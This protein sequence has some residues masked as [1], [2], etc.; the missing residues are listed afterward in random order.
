MKNKAVTPVIFS[1]VVL[2]LCALAV[3]ACD[4]SGG[5]T[6]GGDIPGINANAVIRV[7]RD[8]LSFALGMEIDDAD[9]IV[10]CGL[11]LVDDEGGE[12]EIEKQHLTSGSVKYERFDLSAKG[13]NKQI[14]ITYKK[15]ESYIFYDVIDYVVEF[16]ADAEH[17]RLYKKDS[18]KAQFTDS[19]DLS[20]YADISSY[21]YSTDESAKKSDPVGTAR[22]NGWY[23]ESGNPVTGLHLF[24]PPAEG[25][26]CGLKLHAKYLT[27]EQFSNL[28]LSYSGNERVFS[29]YNGSERSQRV[30]VPEGVTYI[31][32]GA[33]FYATPTV[34][35]IMFESLHIPST[36]HLDLP[37]RSFVNT[38]GLKEIT[39]DGGS[40]EYSGY[41]GA[42][43]NKDGTKLYLMPASLTRV[44]FAP[45]LTTFESLSCAY[46]QVKKVALPESVTA[47]G[48][49]CFAY[50]DVEEVEGLEKVHNRGTGIFLGTPVNA[51]YDG[52]TALYTELADGE[53]TLSM[54]LDKSITSY[55]VIDGTIGVDGGA[56]A[57]C[58]SLVSVD[59]SGVRGIG[60]SAFSECTSLQKVTFSD[61]LKY[62]GSAVFYNCSSLAV[63]DGFDVGDITFTSDTGTY[64][65]TLSDRLF[66]G[67]EKLVSVKIPE[68]VKRIGSE[69][70]YGCLSLAEVIMPDGVEIIDSKAFYGCGFKSISLPKSLVS[71]GFGV[72]ADS[73]LESVDLETCPNLT[74]L[75][76]NCFDGTKLKTVTLP[77]RVSEIPDRCFY[78]IETLT[79][80]DLNNVKSVGER[81]FSYCINLSEIDFGGGLTYIGYRAFGNCGALTEVVL[82]D[83]VTVVDSYAFA[84]CAALRKITLG[85]N[86]EVFGYYPVLEDGVTFGSVTPV[87]WQCDSL[88]EIAVKDGNA[89]FTAVDGVLYGSE[90]NGENLGVGSVLYTIP[91]SYPNASLTLPDTVKIV[92]PYSLQ[93][94]IKDTETAVIS[95]ITLNEGIVNI[96]KAAF[97]NSKNLKGLKIPSTVTNLGASILLECS[98]IERFEIA[99]ENKV[100]FSDGDLIYKGNVLIACMRLGDSVNIREGTEAIESA[101][102]MG[103]TRITDVEIPSGVKTIGYQAFRGCSNLVSLKLGADVESIDSYAFAELTSLRTVEIAADNKHFKVVN[104][105]LYS[106]DGTRL[107]LAPALNAMTSLEIEDTVTEIGDWAFAYNKTLKSVKI[108]S[109]VKTIG[110]YAFYECRAV[111][112]LF[113]GSSL[114]TIDDWAFSF[115]TSVNPADKTE[116]RYCDTLQTVMLQSCTVRI[117]D[118]AFYGHY[119][120]QSLYLRMTADEAD[121]LIRASGTNISFLTD[122]CPKGEGV[123]YNNVT[124]YLYSPTRPVINVDGYK[125]FRLDEN[126]NPVPWEDTEFNV[127]KSEV[128]KL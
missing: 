123:N 91:P 54:I 74:V 85:R 100:Y 57:G 122:G 37:L 46:W 71:L 47:L 40:R 110:R 105:I 3:A 66:Y 21:N 11:K 70:F 17:T 14:K 107:I 98:G 19:L 27:E 51:Y 61:S 20:V 81:A 82:P 108:P 67:C 12:V 72:F 101:V 79:K 44:E 4:C 121:R 56:F 109:H 10:R 78:H 65:H 117:G 48:D 76:E 112:E 124:R 1:I 45:S 90:S 94:R 18:A 92:L 119:G 111:E 75:S 43:Y 116:M 6:P 77:D 34:T 102:F 7:E 126:G 13:R 53:Y 73:M 15:A 35:D 9:I 59:L 49:Y 125:W 127:R 106:A 36:A 31:D 87:L 50:S 89:Y 38:A 93:Y 99:A 24:A 52:D 88:A 25:A 120:I 41:G 115:K 96:G 62:L 33:L 32:L 95:E 64:E 68:G 118:W 16:Y 80:V 58:T 60:D 26:E 83:T 69:A 104:N 8:S 128:A 29:G 63:L 55:K 22:F 28:K 113:G 42:L 97:Y 86:V 30:I 5:Y 84:T 2:S 39:V 23:D 114:Q 103:N